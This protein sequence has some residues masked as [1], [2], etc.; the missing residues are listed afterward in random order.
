MRP[1]V[2]L[3]LYFVTDAQLSA[4]RGLVA[5]V[6]AAVRGGAT[7]VQLRDPLA[8][9]GALVEQGRALLAA[10]RP[11]GVPLI[12]N[13]R[14]D[15]ARAID[16][17]GVHVGQGDLPAEAARAILGPDAI[18]GLSITAPQE[19]AGVPWDAVDHLGVGP[20]VSRGVK[21]DAAE[22]MGLAGLAACGRL[23]RKPIVA[24]GGMDAASAGPCIAAGAAGVAAVAAIAGADDP[25]AS[26][27]ELKSRVAAALAAR[28]NRLT[29]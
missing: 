26:A 16:A 21:P 6:L 7:I 14:P 10:L 15:V 2:D 1:H 19:M 17:D 27:R 5:T 3:S 29:P 8:K 24:I 28:S 12:I 13:D 22:P 4:G 20:V 11:L 23:S 25:E 18:V 9:A